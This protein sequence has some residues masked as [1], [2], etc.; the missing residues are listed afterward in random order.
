ML[1]QQSFKHL[2]GSPVGGARLNQPVRVEG[3]D[4]S[5]VVKVEH[6]PLGLAERLDLPHPGGGPLRAVLVIVSAAVGAT[7]ELPSGASSRLR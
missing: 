3:V 4:W 6:Q 7:V 2:V 5:G 1:V